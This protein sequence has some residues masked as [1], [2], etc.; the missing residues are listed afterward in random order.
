MMTPLF[1]PPT[2]LQALQAGADCAIGIS[3]GKDSQALLSSFLPWF[4]DQGFQGNV[5]AIHADLGRAEWSQTPSFVRSVCKQYHIELVVV[6][7]GRGDLLHR[8]EERLAAVGD[9]APFWPSSAARYCTSDLKRSPIDSR[10][11]KAQCIMS[12]EGI[13]AAESDAR[14]EKKPLTVRHSITAKRYRQL[15]LEACWSS[16]CEDRQASLAVPQQE[17]LFPEVPGMVR[18]TQHPPRL[19]LTLYP[20]FY[21]S[22]EDVWHACGTSSDELAHR[23]ALYKDGLTSESEEKR[24]LALA[25]W[26]A[27]PAYVLGANRLSCSLCVLG[28]GETLRAGAYHNPDYYRSLCL[29]EAQTGWSFQPGRWLC[30]IAPELLTDEILALLAQQPRRLRWQEE[31]RTK[32]RRVVLPII[33][34]S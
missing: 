20:L 24:Q 19:A 33:A 6:Q 23:R 11:R 32:K 5:F 31:Q 21:W 15:P 13:R 25:G 22:E 14:A 8:I 28:D 16:F 7:R 1:L 10:L 12:L 27:H 30:D 2:A 26:P 34:T 3:G 17:L 29:L 18:Q 9:Q 4:R